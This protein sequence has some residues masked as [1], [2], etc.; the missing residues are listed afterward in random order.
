MLSPDV[1]RSGVHD[2]LPSTRRN[3]ILDYY[4]KKPVHR[5]TESH[6]NEMDN[7]TNEGTDEYILKPLKFG[8]GND[9]IPS[10]FYSDEKVDHRLV[11]LNYPH[12]SV[13]VQ[14]DGQIMKHEFSF[15]KDEDDT[16]DTCAL[17]LKSTSLTDCNTLHYVLWV[18]RSRQ[19]ESERAITKALDKANREGTECFMSVLP[20]PLTHV[21]E[22][23]QQRVNEEER[24]HGEWRP[25]WT[26]YP[27][28]LMPSYLYPSIK[29]DG[30][31]YIE[32]IIS[33][34]GK[35]RWMNTYVAFMEMHPN[36]ADRIK[37]TSPQKSDVT[38]V[39]IPG[40]LKS[41]DSSCFY[42]F[43]CNESPWEIKGPCRERLDNNDSIITDTL[44]LMKLPD[45]NAPWGAY[46]ANDNVDPFMPQSVILPWRFNDN[47]VSGRPTEVDTID[48]ARVRTP[49]GFEIMSFV[50][51]EGVLMHDWKP[52]PNNTQRQ[53]TEI[54]NQRKRDKEKER[55]GRRD[56]RAQREVPPS[57]TAEE[58]ER[59]AQSFLPEKPTPP[60]P[61]PKA[62]P[63]K[64][65]K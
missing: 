61:K 27:E 14:P 13:M 32:C 44:N 1:I 7:I 26:C 33:V 64:K 31:G 59:I 52:I 10:P 55:S 63:K 28:T 65:K 22:K 56:R 16:D 23:L 17:W 36:V 24:V 46:L 37:A 39:R 49:G 15:A 62:K 57:V 50:D 45:D 41:N 53:L 2:A 8:M 60:R 30:G 29:F 40:S 58:K 21:I 42:A 18:L 34:Q 51:Y 43:E 4:R 54:E 6:D 3:T 12:V 5:Y 35:P 38:R 47:R 9:G 48:S 20:P 11:F 19:Y 25:S